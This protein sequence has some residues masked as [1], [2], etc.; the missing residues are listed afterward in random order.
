MMHVFSSLPAS[1]QALVFG[2]MT[3]LSGA[4]LEKNGGVEVVWR[5]ARLLR[6]FMAATD[7]EKR[8]V[9]KTLAILR[10]KGGG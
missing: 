9:E 4:S 3:M 7:S 6:E 5:N 1:Q 10:G 8:V 2:M